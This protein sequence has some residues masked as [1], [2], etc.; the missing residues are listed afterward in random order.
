LLAE[1]DPPFI[2]APGSADDDVLG[3]Q[4]RTLEPRMKSIGLNQQCSPLLDGQI[5]RKIRRKADEGRRVDFGRRRAT[6]T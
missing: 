5:A 3:D 1:G 2:R 6:Y 4:K